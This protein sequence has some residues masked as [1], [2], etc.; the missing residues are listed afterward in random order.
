LNIQSWGIQYIL[1]WVSTL[2]VHVLLSSGQELKGE[3]E[4][5]AEGEGNHVDEKTPEVFMLTGRVFG[6]EDKIKLCNRN[7]GRN[8]EIVN[9]QN[10]F[11]EMEQVAKERDLHWTKDDLEHFRN[12]GED[13]ECNAAPATL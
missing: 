4:N 11:G 2:V 1:V 6:D 10:I 7:S 12:L 9:H 8:F 13:A 3:L 5:E